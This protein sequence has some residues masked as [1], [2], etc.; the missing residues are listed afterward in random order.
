MGFSTA[1]DVCGGHEHGEYTCQY[2]TQVVNITSGSQGAN[3]GAPGVPAGLSYPAT[4]SGPYYCFK[5]NLTAADK[6]FGRQ[7]NPKKVSHCS[8]MTNYYVR[9]ANVQLKD[10]GTQ[11]VSTVFSC[12]AGSYNSIY[13]ASSA[14]CSACAADTY[15]AAGAT[16]CTPCATGYSSLAGASACTA[17]TTA[18]GTFSLTALPDASFSGSSL[19]D[20]AVVSLTSALTTALKSASST[21]AIKVTIT[22]LPRRL[23]GASSTGRAASHLAL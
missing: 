4:T 23:P 7:I 1:L 10:A 6:Y 21:T 22:R 3:V 15:S 2:H 20:A 8:G 16:S 11:A 12:S 19:T 14:S 5:G 13:G 18:T 9:D 17:S